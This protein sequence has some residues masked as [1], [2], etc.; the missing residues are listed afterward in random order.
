MPFYHESDIAGNIY[1]GNLYYGDVFY[2]TDSGIY[3]RLEISYKYDF[4]DFLSLKVASV[5]HYD[6]YGWGWQQLVQL[7]VN[8]NNFQF[9]VKSKAYNQHH[10]H[11]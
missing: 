1:G 11:R 10:H 9:P 5:H 7:V 3:N 8:L 6:G 4:K 2:S